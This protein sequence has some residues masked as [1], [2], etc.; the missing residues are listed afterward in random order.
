[1]GKIWFIFIKGQ[2]EGPFTYLE[3]SRDDRLTPDVYAWREGMADW[4]LVGE[5]PELKSLVGQDDE[6][7]EDSPDEDDKQSS[8]EDD[9]LVLE[10]HKGRHYPYLW[11]ILLLIIFLYTAYEIFWT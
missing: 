4:E 11:L 3:L 2:Q 7:E 6:I 1:M 8:P 5:I 10:M 9:E